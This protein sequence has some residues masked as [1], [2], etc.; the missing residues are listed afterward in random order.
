MT[1]FYYTDINYI[2]D[3]EL[4]YD[5]L[6]EYRREKIDRLVHD[7]DK[8]A[9]LCAGLLIDRFIGKTEIKLG[10][11]GKPYASNGRRFNISHSG[12]YVIIAVSDNEVGCDVEMC[13]EADYERLGKVVFHENE[14]STLKN[15]EDKQ[16]CF[17]R[18]W[19]MKEAFIKCLGEGFHFKTASLDL[20]GVRDSLEYNGETFFFKEYMLKGAKIMLC[21]RDKNLP[22]QIERINF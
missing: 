18:F 8:K 20:S 3:I 21:S 4:Y 19:T 15:S 2:S 22:A 7:A 17:Y 9:S 5:T 16:E 12:N 10:R 1:E 13:R 6:S 11:Y 14:L